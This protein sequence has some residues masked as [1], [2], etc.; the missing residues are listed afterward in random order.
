MLQRAHHMQWHHK[1][2]EMPVAYGVMPGI[3]PGGGY[4]FFL[5][6]VQQ[7]QLR[8]Q[9]RENRDLGAAAP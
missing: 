2:C 1:V 5:G 6:G 7:I 3:F 9:G 4:A 8:I